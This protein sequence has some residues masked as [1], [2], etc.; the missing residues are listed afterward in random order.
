M[1]NLE[2]VAK[3]RKGVNKWN[4][5]KNKQGNFEVDLTETYLTELNLAGVNLRLA[6]LNT[7]SLA[8]TNL[9]YADL[10]GASLWAADLREADLRGANLRGA[11]LSLARFGDTILGDT[12]FRDAKGLESS[13]H[14]QPSLIDHQTLINS[15]PLALAFLRGCGLP[16]EFITFIPSLLNKAI[17]FYSCFITYS[18]KDQE[19]ADRL[20]A[21]LQNKGV[22]CWFAP[23]DLKIGDRFQDRIE[24][25]IRLHDKVMIVLS[26]ASVSSAWVERE[27]LA[28]RER[29]D[30]EKRTVLFPIRIDD[31]VLAATQPWAADV[32]RGRHIGDFSTWQTHES[33]MKAFGRLLRDLTSETAK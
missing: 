10:S 21:D 6:N 20:Y 22:R 18:T 8:R 9:R 23:E 29:E 2:H 31:A 19:F 14:I 1:A 12:N 17:Q 16:D 24:E 13:R 5:W 33:Y 30:R 3:L 26:E 7:A 32:R 25:S 11:K 28:A 4:P 27:V 15:G